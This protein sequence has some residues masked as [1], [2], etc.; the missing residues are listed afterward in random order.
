MIT[1][2][3]AAYVFEKGPVCSI[4]C[5]SRFKSNT[6]V[7]FLDQQGVAVTVIN[8]NKKHVYIELPKRSQIDFLSILENAAWDCD[9]ML[10]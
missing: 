9:L 7:T 10:G 5:T 2:L 3:P 1:V 8:I 6:I 4:G